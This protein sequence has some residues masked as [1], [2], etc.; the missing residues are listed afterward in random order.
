M[1][2]GNKLSSHGYTPTSIETLGSLLQKD[3]IIYYASSRK[4]PYLRMIEMM[5]KILYFQK[6]V[7][8]LLIDTYSTRSFWYA[9]CCSMLAKI[10]GIQYVPILHGGNL[11]ERLEKNPYCSNLIFR[12]SYRNISPSSYLKQAF[13]KKGYAV[14][15]IPNNLEIQNYPYSK[16]TQL[17]PKLLWVRSFDAGYNPT[18]AVRVLKRLSQYYPNAELCMVGPEKDGSLQSCQNLARELN[19]DHKVSFTGRLPKTEWIRLSQNY[20]VFISTTR[21]D[22]TPVSLMEAMALGLPVVSTNVGGVPYL[23]KDGKTGLLVETDDIQM[24]CQKV[25][26]LIRNPKM[27]SVMAQNARKKVESFDWKKIKHHWFQLLQ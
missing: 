1:Y 15:L 21:V 4:N 27:A 11:P 7:T 26:H 9:L 25:I 19:V 3:F 16:R 22:N 20:D 5:G 17:R 18:M 8:F 12:H 6:K 13:E 10:L 23:I 14:T 2:I 24:M